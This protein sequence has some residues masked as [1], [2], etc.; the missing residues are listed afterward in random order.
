MQIE[1]TETYLEIKQGDKSLFY[2]LFPTGCP[3]RK[4]TVYGW[5]IDKDDNEVAWR[6]KLPSKL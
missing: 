5:K 2:N 1:K 6:Y 3:I 4:A